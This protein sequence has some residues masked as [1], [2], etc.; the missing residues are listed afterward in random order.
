MLRSLMYLLDDINV[1]IYENDISYYALI[2]Y[3]AYL[4]T[5]NSEHLYGSLV[6]KYLN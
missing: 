3:N 2:Q 6:F 4:I 5:N 1:L